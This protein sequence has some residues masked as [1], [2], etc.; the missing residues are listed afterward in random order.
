MFYDPADGNFTVPRMT[1]SLFSG[2]LDGPVTTTQIELQDPKDPTLVLTI[3]NSGGRVVI[4]Q[5]GIKTGSAPMISPS[6]STDGVEQDI[7]RGLSATVVSAPGKG[8]ANCAKGYICTASRGR[9]TVVAPATGATGLIASV[10]TTL[11]AGTICT[12]TQNGGSSFFGIGSERESA[13][14][15]DITAAVVLHGM[16]TVDYSCH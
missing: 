1:A 16:A 3:A 6:L 10:R 2:R 5:H 12:A 9:L 11:H 7:V 13:N 15:F 14:G 8:S 4:N